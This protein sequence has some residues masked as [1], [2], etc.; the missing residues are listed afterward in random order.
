MYCVTWICVQVFQLFFLLK[1]NFNI[2][3]ISILKILKW[4]QLLL[5]LQRTVWNCICFWKPKVKQ[6]VINIVVCCLHKRKDKNKNVKKKIGENTSL[7]LSVFVF[8]S[9]FFIYALLEAAIEKCVCEIAFYQIKQ[10]PWKIPAKVIIATKVAG[11]RPL[12]LLKLT[13]SQ[14]F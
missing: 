4:N 2:K 1:H 5:Y 12:T 8:C 9:L 13:L 3:N 6:K 10:N 14:M 7:M 11:C